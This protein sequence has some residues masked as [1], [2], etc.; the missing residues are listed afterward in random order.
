MEWILGHFN[1]K[2][3]L[4][5]NDKSLWLRLKIFSD[6]T[7]LT[8][9][10]MIVDV[11]TQPSQHAR[12]ITPRC[13]SQ[14]TSLNMH[15]KYFNLMSPHKMNIVVL[16]RKETKEEY[17]IHNFLQLCVPFFELNETLANGA[18]RSFY[19]FVSPQTYIISIKRIQNL[20]DKFNFQIWINHK[21]KAAISSLVFCLFLNLR[22]H[23]RNIWFFGEKKIPWYLLKKSWQDSPY[24]SENLSE[25]CWENICMLYI[26][27]LWSRCHLMAGDNSG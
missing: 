12:V 1:D 18:R 15:I 9:G 11:A 24:W 4:L 3:V 6:V 16:T 10:P 27:W 17:T 2:S 23:A 25:N 7:M 14:V 13:T 19:V 26:F 22:I 8:P 20:P 21:S 5:V